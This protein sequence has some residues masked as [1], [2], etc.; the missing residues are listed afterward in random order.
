[1]K[2]VCFCGIDGAGKTTQAELLVTQLKKESK[3][4]TYIHLFSQRGTFGTQFHQT[5]WLSP[6]IK[7]IR[8]KKES[9]W[10]KR[11]NIIIRVVNLFLD[12]W[13]TTFINR[14]KYKDSLIVYDRYFYDILAILISEHPRLEFLLLKFIFFLP[15]PKL[16]F[17]L[18][19]NSNLY[20]NLAKKVKA[21]V[22]NSQLSRKKIAKQIYHSLST[23]E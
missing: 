17:I 22:I 7:F 18:D 1:M 13:I 16:V 11:F 21:K 2:T 10:G 3:N 20:L 6:I 4:P 5:F 8:I 9:S 15:R 12:S 19:K 14:V 23:N